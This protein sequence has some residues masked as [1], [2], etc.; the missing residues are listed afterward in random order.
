MLRLL[1]HG[2]SARVDSRQ[3]SMLSDIVQQG[4]L[5]DALQA[6]PQFRGSTEA[7]MTAWL[8]QSSRS[9]AWR[10]K[11]ADIMEPRN[12]MS[13]WKSPS[14]TVSRGHRSCLGDNSSGQLRTVTQSKRRSPRTGRAA[15]RRPGAIEGRLSRKS[16]TCG[17]SKFFVARTNRCPN[18]SHH[19]RSRPHVM[20]SSLDGTEAGTSLVYVR[21]SLTTHAIKRNFQ[22]SGN[23]L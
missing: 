10:T 9:R 7:E 12:A 19:D 6:F 2:F 1:L 8:R 15:G 20:D 4:L 23:W 11:F 14:P 21:K 18:E 16:F 13:R 17:T 22:D 3:S 5:L